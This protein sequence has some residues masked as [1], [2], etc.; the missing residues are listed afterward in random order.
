MSHIILSTIIKFAVALAARGNFT[1]LP[2]CETPPAERLLKNE[3]SSYL[4]SLLPQQRLFRT[5]IIIYPLWRSNCTCLS[6]ALWARLIVTH[7]L[8]TKLWTWATLSTPCP[9]EG[10]SVSFYPQTITLSSTTLW[11]WA[12]LSTQY[13]EEGFSVSFYPQHKSLSNFNFIAN[14]FNPIRVSTSLKNVPLWNNF[15]LRQK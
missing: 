11:K 14:K 10:S 4:S 9:E 5:F 1:Y 2:S 12:T 15:L 8:S 13:P 6:S 7:F 3:S